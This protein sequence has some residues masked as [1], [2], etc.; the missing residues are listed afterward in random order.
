LALY[1]SAESGWKL[2]MF[3]DTCRDP[4]TVVQGVCRGKVFEKSSAP[5]SA[6]T[7]CLKGICISTSDLVSLLETFDADEKVAGFCAENFPAGA[8]EPEPEQVPGKAACTLD[9]FSTK[10]LA[11]HLK[12]RTGTMSAEEKQ[13][14]SSSLGFEGGACPQQQAGIGGGRGGSADGGCF[15]TEQM[16][17]QMTPEQMSSFEQRC[18]QQQASPMMGGM[19]RDTVPELQG[20]SEEQR[21]KMLFGQAPQGYPSG[22]SQGMGPDQMQKMREQMGAP[23]PSMQRSAAVENGMP[24]MPG[25]DYCAIDER[26]KQ[27]M[28][29]E[30]VNQWQARCGPQGMRITGFFSR[31]GNYFRK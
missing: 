31:F 27:T 4:A 2:G 6:G 15:I 13:T 21:K 5:C 17:S 8:D 14:F 24:E 29:Q 12:Q 19:P 3:S 30:Q 28:T 25:A 9:S 18:K 10:E 26:M 20:L 22:F 16:K 23:L 11:A 7:A 1:R